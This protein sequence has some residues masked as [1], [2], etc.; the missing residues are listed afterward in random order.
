MAI[1]E[2]V[3]EVE[4]IKW[5]YREARPA[6][7]N[8]LPPVLLLH[9]LPAQSYSWTQIMPALAEQGLRSLAPDWIGFGLSGKPDARD[10][11]YT[12]DAF[13]E[14]LAALVKTLQ[15]EELYLVVQGFLGSV[16]LQWA[17]RN[18]DLVSRLVILN[19]PVSS[20]AKLPWKIQQ[21]GLPF[22]GDM[23]T[24]DPLLVDR[25]LEGGSG[26]TISD[27]DLDIYRRP[28][29]TTSAAGRSLLATVRKIQLSQA[30][31]EIESGFRQWA[32]PTLIVWGIADPWLPVTQAKELASSMSNAELVQLEQVGHYPQEH[33]S[34]EINKSLVPFLRRTET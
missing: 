30:M 33:W 32:K 2:Q 9:G 8:G 14:A 25:T 18:P 11:A 27:E 7:E 10:F 3:I 31:T 28:F 23:V 20:A 4:G 6:E 21:L 13:I 29:L 17:L 12:P 19:T 22:F 34:E 15:L 5:F 24:Q 16:G 26:Y 1:D